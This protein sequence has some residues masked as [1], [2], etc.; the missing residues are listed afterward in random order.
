LIKFEIFNM[1]KKIHTHGGK[2]KGAG[3]KPKHGEPTR[4][5]GVVLPESLAEW[6]ESQPGKS[7]SDVVVEA[8]EEAR[9]KADL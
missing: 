5:K 1:A 8:L 9:K 2:R 6:A 7:F 4:T 3:R